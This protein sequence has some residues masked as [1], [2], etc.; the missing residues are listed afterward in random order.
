MALPAIAPH[1]VHKWEGINVDGVNRDVC[2][3]RL[4]HF[5]WA[6]SKEGQQGPRRTFSSQLYDPAY[7]ARLVELFQNSI[8]QNLQRGSIN[9]ACFLP[10]FVYEIEE[11]SGM[12]VALFGRINVLTNPAGETEAVWGIV[13]PTDPQTHLIERDPT[14]MTEAFLTHSPLLNQPHFETIMR[15][16]KQV[17]KP[18]K[19]HCEMNEY[20]KHFRVEIVR[21]TAAK[22]SQVFLKCVS[23]LNPE[24]SL[25]ERDWA[26]TLVS[27]PDA[28]SGFARFWAGGPVGHAMLAYEGMRDQKPVL[29]YVHAIPSSIPR[30][31]LIEHFESSR[32]LKTVNGPSWRR[33][34][35]LIENMLAFVKSLQGKFIH[36]AVEGHLLYSMRIND[37]DGWDMITRNEWIQGKSSSPEMFT[38]MRQG[39]ET[40]GS[41]KVSE[42]PLRQNCLDYATNISER[43]GVFFYGHT[44]PTRPLRKI[45]L[46]RQAPIYQIPEGLHHLV[47]TEVSLINSGRQDVVDGMLSACVILTPPDCP[48]SDCDKWSWQSIFEETWATDREIERLLTLRTLTE[49]FKPYNYK[50][51]RWK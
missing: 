45:E 49:L 42:Y 13:D 32:P 10:K 34:R 33:S 31:G 37:P 29:G 4:D 22:I 26:L 36:F 11:G 35:E 20:V 44:S 48:P 47:P 16:G 6:F 41:V 50:P 30:L 40:P 27:T 28:S 19:D 39:M 1:L 21:D 9:G 15:D 2:L 3:F 18:A 24:C 43:A 51:K 7:A 25:T 8:R 14:D 5:Q 17:I 46:V 23:V 38:L 12:Y